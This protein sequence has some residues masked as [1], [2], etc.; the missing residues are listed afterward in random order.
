MN[1][2]GIRLSTAVA[3]F[4]VIAA[5]GTSQTIETNDAPREPA[6]FDRQVMRVST[7]DS[8]G[9]IKSVDRCVWVADTSDKRRRGLMG[10]TTLGAADGMLFVQEQPTSGAF[11]M[12][13]TLIDLSIAFFNQDGEFLDAMNMSPCLATN[14]NDCPRYQTPSSYVFALEVAQGDLAELGIRS[15]S[16]ITLVDQTCSSSTARE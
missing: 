2:R 15:A 14:G 16:I 6:G 11:W 3:A 8:A 1:L 12:K 5:C 7:G 9:G 10:V 4:G 13:D